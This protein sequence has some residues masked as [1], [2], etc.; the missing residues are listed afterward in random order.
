MSLTVRKLAANETAYLQFGDV[1]VSVQ[2]REID[3]MEGVAIGVG[4]LICFA[5]GKDK[6]P[7][8]HD[9]TGLTVWQAKE[10]RA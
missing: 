9:T 2:A 5:G 4:P 7:I 10:G 6:K 3:A 1:F 8:I